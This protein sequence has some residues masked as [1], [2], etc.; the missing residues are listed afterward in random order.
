MTLRVFVMQQDAQYLIQPEEESVMCNAGLRPFL[1][2][3]LTLGMPVPPGSA[4]AGFRV[5]HAFAGG[6]DG[7]YPAGSVLK[8]G[9]NIYGTTVL[10][11]ANDKG[12]VFEIAPDGTETVLYSFKGGTDGYKPESVL[13]RDKAGNLYGT[14]YF[15][16]STEQCGTVFK[17]APDGTETVLHRFVHTIDGCNTDTGVILD[18]KGNLYGAVYS[19][20]TYPA[21][22]FKLR[23]DG[24]EKIL[25]QFAASDNPNRDLLMDDAGNL[26]GTTHDG[27][28]NAKGSIY[29]LAPDGTETTI[30]DFAGGNDGHGPD[31]G[32]IAD[33]SGNLYGTTFT[34]GSAS[35]GIVYKVA[36]DGTETVLHAFAGAPDDAC[37]P[38]FGRLSLDGSGNLYGMTYFGGAYN[39]GSV[40]KVAPD[41]S[42][43]I[44]HSF[45]GSDG[46]WPYASAISDKKG[47]LYGT[48]ITGGSGGA[49]VVVRLNE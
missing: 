11:G 34:G 39:M 12:T 16:G 21:S 46:E 10:G 20:G 25:Y 43:T 15:G 33:S 18:R 4:H 1:A 42:S 38:E 22:V 49:G 27:G 28:T 14:T 2:L 35:C 13:V 8:A 44:L 24:K 6:S 36:P 32:P 45:D 31:S 30:Y 19:Y 5:L 47:H 17:V 40:F 26:Y 37:N 3:C 23:P 48:T 41:G 9:G 7:A 29:K